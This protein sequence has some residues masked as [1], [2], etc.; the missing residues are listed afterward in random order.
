MHPL[1]K[2]P[3]MGDVPSRHSEDRVIRRIELMKGLHRT[4]ASGLVG[5]AAGALMGAAAC[6]AVNV[7]VPSTAG[8]ETLYPSGRGLYS[9]NSYQDSSGKYY[10]DDPL[11]GPKGG[12][13]GGG[14]L[15]DEDGNQYDCDTS[16][17]CSPF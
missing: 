13:Y 8:A 4:V 10:D 14:V 17:S 16:G 2:I 3:Q 11:Y 12:L 5:G 9:G 6:L 7:L 1:K 15:V